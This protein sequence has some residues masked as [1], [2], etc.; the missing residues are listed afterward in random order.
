MATLNT[1][2]RLVTP[3]RD[4]GVNQIFRIRQT[5]IVESSD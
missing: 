3:P 1:K 5:Q 4:G 2:F